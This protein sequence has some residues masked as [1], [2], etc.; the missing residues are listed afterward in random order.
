MATDKENIVVLEFPG[1]SH[2]CLFSICYSNGQHDQT[3]LPV[4][5]F[6]KDP[7]KC[8]VFFEQLISLVPVKLI[9]GLVLLAKL[10]HPLNV[11]QK[12]KLYF[13]KFCQS[14]GIFYLFPTWDIISDYGMLGD[15]KPYISNGDCVAVVNA[16]EDIDF[17]VLKRTGRCIEFQEV[18]VSSISDLATLKKT[19]MG[20]Y[21]L[22]QLLFIKASE[23][24]QFETLIRNS[25]EHVIKAF[26][27]VLIAYNNAPDP[28]HRLNMDTYS[29]VELIRIAMGEKIGTKYDI[30]PFFDRDIEIPLLIKCKYGEILPFEKSVIREVAD[31]KN[32][33]LREPIFGMLEN[34][35]FVPTDA[36]N[37][38][39]T[40]TVDMNMFY[41]VKVEPVTTETPKPEAIA[42]SFEKNLK[43]KDVVSQKAKIVFTQ[44][45]F[46]VRI[47]ENGGEQKMI[48]DS[49][50]IAKIPLYISFMEKKP[51]IGEAAVKC[52][53]KN[54]NF[55]VYDLMKLC[56]NNFDK[57]DPKWSFKLN[58]NCNNEMSVEFET[59]NG[60][61]K[62]SPDFL[63][64]IIFNHCMKLIEKETGKKMEEIGIE[65][66]GLEKNEII[67][68]C[69]EK[70]GKKINVKLNFL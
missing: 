49:D 33:T 18:F 2:A 13:K 6:F 60:P 40:L 70:A 68:S 32:I 52:A 1:F 11:I 54:P 65:F 3:F 59:S 19:I 7:S 23:G 69:F 51:V 46:S 48:N 29:C 37:V 10:K 39:I 50:G 56:S 63:L 20:K 61:R 12:V 30:K 4:T 62:A 53:E 15:I 47:L 17:R 5:D 67:A 27:G 8:S 42:L 35:S 41:K 25:S 31:V 55:V 21:N 44:D 26:P 24:N 57:V 64:A 22:K 45:Y 43:I 28:Y 9:K 34:I 66:E 38:K 58:R 16:L 14:Y 36:K